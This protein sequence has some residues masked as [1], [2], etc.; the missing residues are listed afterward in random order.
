MSHTDSPALA[1]ATSM[2]YNLNRIP[3]LSG[4]VC[5]ADSPPTASTGGGLSHATE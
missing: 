4:Q 2:V 5:N 3:P 1:M